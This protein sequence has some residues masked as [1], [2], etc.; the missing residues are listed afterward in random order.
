MSRQEK[1]KVRVYDICAPM[2]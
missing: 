1:V 2:F